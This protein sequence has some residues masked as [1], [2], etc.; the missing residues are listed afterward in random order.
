MIR[1][2]FPVIVS[3]SKLALRSQPTLPPVKILLTKVATMMMDCVEEEEC[4]FSTVGNGDQKHISPIDCNRQTQ[5]RT[6]VQSVLSNIVLLCFFFHIFS[7]LSL[8]LTRFSLCVFRFFFEC[9][10]FFYFPGPPLPSCPPLSLNE[11]QKKM[12][13][14][15]DKSWN[16]VRSQKRGLIWES[17]KS[18]VARARARQMIED[19]MWALVLVSCQSV[20]HQVQHSISHPI[21]GI[22]YR[23]ESNLT[24]QPSE[25]IRDHYSL[26]LLCNDR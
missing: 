16:P 9:E 20:W 23:P 14:P 17:R 5:C 12:E 13:V 26:S 24:F 4:V 15:T 25:N 1:C 8:T 3:N 7:P 19:F 10:M 22:P 6:F 18:W 21:P 2:V 11:R